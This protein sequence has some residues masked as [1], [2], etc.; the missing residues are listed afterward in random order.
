MIHRYSKLSI[1]GPLNDVKV[2][3]AFVWGCP[4]IRYNK[5]LAVMQSKAVGTFN[6]T[7]WHKPQLLEHEI[8]KEAR[9]Y[10]VLFNTRVVLFYDGITF[11][12]FEWPRFTDPLVDKPERVAFLEFPTH[13]ERLR[14]FLLR[15]IFAGLDDKV[16]PFQWL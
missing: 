11:V 8:A 4:D 12:C 13:S 9:A 2:D 14:P 1:Y 10:A 3:F 15:A 7:H 5:V 6:G 16:L